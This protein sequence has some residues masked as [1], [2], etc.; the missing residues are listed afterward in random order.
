MGAAP[1]IPPELLHQ[2]WHP[3]PLL[4]SRA[5]PAQEEGSGCAGLGEGDFHNN[6]GRSL[7]ND[8]KDIHMLI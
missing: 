2:A 1:A 7:R 8:L 5:V 6:F 3:L 4:D